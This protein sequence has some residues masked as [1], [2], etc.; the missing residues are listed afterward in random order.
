MH[1]R[2]GNW[3]V[4]TEAEKFI[5][6]PKG[7]F[8]EHP[9]LRIIVFFIFV[10]G[11]LFLMAAVL[12]VFEIMVKFYLNAQVKY[13]QKL[14]EEEEA[15]LANASPALDNIASATSQE[16][17]KTDEKHRVHGS[18]A[19]DI[20]SFVN[21]DENR[22][23]ALFDLPDNL[24]DLKDR[25]I[26][27]EQALHIKSGPVEVE[28]VSNGLL[29]IRQLVSAPEFQKEIQQHDLHD[30][31][32]TA[33]CVTTTTNDK[34]K[35]GERHAHKVFK[36]SRLF[37]SGAFTSEKWMDRMV[38]GFI[39]LYTQACGFIYAFY[40]Q[41]IMEKENLTQFTPK[42]ISPLEP[43]ILLARSQAMALIVATT[44]MIVLLTRGLCTK[45][46]A[47]ISWSTVLQAL[48]DKHVLIHKSCGYMLVF[49]SFVHCVGHLAQTALNIWRRETLTYSFMG[50]PAVTGYILWVILIAFC[51]FSS[52]KVRKKSFEW[53]FY[54]HVVLI[55]LWTL[56]LILHGGSRWFGFG[57][58]LASI[59]VLP[60][61]MVY[62]IE[63]Y[64]HV[65][66]GSDETIHIAHATV[67]GK[68]A[69]VT[70]DIGKSKLSYETGQYSMLMVP[71]IAGHEWH[72]FTIASGGGQ[73]QFDLL[74]ANAG[75]WTSEL[76][77]LI[78]VGNKQKQPE[79]PS[80]CVRGGYGAPAQGMKDKHHIVMVGGGVGCTPF[81]SFLSSACNA[82]TTQENA[83]FPDLKSAVFFWVSR[84]PE[85]FKWVNQYAE[86]IERNPD[87]ASRIEIRLCLTKTLESSA[88]ASVSQTDLSLFWLGVQ[89]AMRSQGDHKELAASLGVPTQFGRPKWDE[90]F[91]QIATQ[92]MSSHG[93][94]KDKERFEISVF[95]CGNPMLTESLEKACA[96]NTSSRVMMRLYAEEF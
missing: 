27:S 49:A 70:I 80:I 2:H 89:R 64:W 93:H 13:L 42:N 43:R 7:E 66:W 17:P 34:Y 25:V 72:P 10:I 41:E 86:I 1:L 47:L 52:E 15:K 61:C 48:I 82:A 6:D 28:Q 46:R 71:E 18:E 20:W 14:D 84:D 37:A 73:Q 24:Q 21:G 76:H 54:P 60:V 79:Y 30:G 65:R 57:L 3:S 67:T 4:I 38:I 36:D 68:T 81:L 26:A 9:E 45:L 94:D 53:F 95:A 50:W 8:V 58:P 39:F 40:L 31:C 87:L 74:I 77:R 59:S 63:R 29:E 96:A 92:L 55:C 90:E 44:L 51:A 78:Q 56:F 75:D 12:G 83:I 91:A 85:D 11:L 23:K 32:P 33:G 62:F 35:D 5:S 22:L 88:T 16:S 19:D 69:S